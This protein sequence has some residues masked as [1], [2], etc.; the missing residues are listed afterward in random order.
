FKDQFRSAAHLAT[1]TS[2][3]VLTFVVNMFFYFLFVS[4]CCSLATHIN[5]TRTSNPRQQF[6]FIKIFV[7][8]K[9]AEYSQI[10]LP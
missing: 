1:R 9:Y 6:F 10:S 5:I 8:F 3:H 4:R 2:Y 7:S